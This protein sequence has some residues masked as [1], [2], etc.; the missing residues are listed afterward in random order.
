M[1][2][3]TTVALNLTFVVTLGVGCLMFFVHAI[4]FAALLAVTAAAQLVGF[5]VTAVRQRLSRRVAA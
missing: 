3:P 1:G 2:D 4:L 5:I